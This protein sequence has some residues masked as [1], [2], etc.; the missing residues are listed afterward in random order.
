LFD[1][2][3]RV[4]LQLWNTILCQF[5]SIINFMFIILVKTKYLRKGN[6]IVLYIFN[7]TII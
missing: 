5:S 7:E 3:G 6:N 1:S 4:G 2:S